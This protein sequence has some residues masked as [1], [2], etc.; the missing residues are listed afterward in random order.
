MPDNDTEPDEGFELVCG[1]DEVPDLMPRRV[2]V[3]GR[4]VLVCKTDDGFSAVDEICP[5]KDRS[6][7]Y[8]VVQRGQI[9]CPHHRY[10]FDLE[11]GRCRRRCPPVAVYEVKVVDGDIYVRPS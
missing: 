4:G 7:R 11:T 5:H 3:N 10:K 2:E 1:V 8:G 6:M 9:I